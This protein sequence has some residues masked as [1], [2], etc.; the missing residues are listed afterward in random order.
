MSS[1]HRPRRKHGAHRGPPCTTQTRRAGLTGLISGRSEAR[2]GVAGCGLVLL[3]KL[4]GAG[5]GS[6]RRVDSDL[7]RRDRLLI[8]VQCHEHDLAGFGHRPAEPA[9]GSGLGLEFCRL[10][11]DGQVVQNGG[12][13]LLV[14]HLTGQHGD[15]LRL[16]AF[17]N[18][19]GAHAGRPDVSAG[20]RDP[21]GQR[22]CW[23]ARLAERLA[24]WA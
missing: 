18:D 5:Q 4:V 8:A 23:S 17:E 14:L 22:E 13:E 20:I 1:I 11:N 7:L 19:Q 15:L 9:Q 6:G 16:I 2:E 24:G 12:D 10:D 21:V 3:Q